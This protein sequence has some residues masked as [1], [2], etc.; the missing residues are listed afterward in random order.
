MYHH[1]RLERRIKRRNSSG[2]IMSSPDVRLLLTSSQEPSHKVNPP[3]HILPVT[4]RKYF[5]LPLKNYFFFCFEA[6]CFYKRQKKK[7]KNTEVKLMKTNQNMTLLWLIQLSWLVPKYWWHLRAWCST[8]KELDFCDNCL[9]A[10]VLH[11]TFPECIIDKDQPCFVHYQEAAKKAERLSTAST[12]WL[13]NKCPQSSWIH[14]VGAE[15]LGKVSFMKTPWTSLL[16]S[17]ASRC[18]I[19]SHLN[20]FS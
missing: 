19:A 12:V 11:H 6:K 16:K 3:A 14:H 7:K 4:I 10:A 9:D 2:H 18:W 8:L 17:L 5:E 13:L 15:A 1:F 20:L